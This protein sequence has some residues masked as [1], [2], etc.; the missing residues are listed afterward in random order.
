MKVTFMRTILIL[1]F[2]I[3]AA[4]FAQ[5]FPEA[6]VMIRGGQSNV[7]GLVL[8]SSNGTIYLSGSISYN[9][10]ANRPVLTGTGSA[11]GLVLSA[12]TDGG[13]GLILSGN[14][15]YNLLSNLPQLLVGGT[16]TASKLTLSRNGQV[17][18]LGGSIDYNDLI[19]KPA[20][21]SG[22]S[23]VTGLTLSASNG[24]ITL[25][26]SAGG[27]LTSGSSQVTGLTLSASN[28]V[29]VLSGSAGGGGLTSGSS[30]VEGLTLSASNGVLV[31]GGT[32][33][34]SS[35]TPVITTSEQGAA[36][37]Q[38]GGVTLGR[39][40]L[41]VKATTAAKFID[42]ND[43]GE[44]I[45]AEQAAD[46]N[47]YG[48]YQYGPTAD[49]WGGAVFKI[50]QDGTVT[51]LHHTPTSGEVTTWGKMPNGM[52][53]DEAGQ[54][55]IVSN[56]YGG[57]DN[58][59]T[60]I[61]VS[62]SSGSTTVLKA[63]TSADGSNP[64]QLLESGS[65]YYGTCQW[66]GNDGRGTA[67]KIEKATGT[68]TKLADFDSTDLASM[69]PDGIGPQL[70]EYNGDFYGVA[71]PRATVNNGLIFKLTTSGSLSA[72]KT[73]A[74]TAET[75]KRAY[76]FNGSKLIGFRRGASPANLAAVD[77]ADGNISTIYNFPTSGYHDAADD[78]HVL[79]TDNG[80]F[81]ASRNF[82]SY[83]GADA[84]S[85]GQ[86]FYIPPEGG[87]YTSL[88]VFNTSVAGGD[89]APTGISFKHGVMLVG[90][91]AG[92]AD[93]INYGRFWKFS[94]AIVRLAPEFRVISGTSTV[95][96]LTI[97]TGTDGVLV[98]SGSMP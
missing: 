69:A 57:P 88:K 90:T 6:D 33:A 96:G 22:T 27:G 1:F 66:G 50:A 79:V 35:S 62:M 3:A 26:G 95:P 56:G 51:I 58:I 64:S 75:F 55:L 36:L 76:G 29:L 65:F 14:V 9:D 38:E 10:L 73:F 83:E 45:Y 13:F 24:V 49:N 41:V 4:G 85:D 60:I 12:R 18:V 84:G 46:G 80:Y 48:V 47:L 63:F 74:S 82:N 71:P 61:A 2:A 67:F 86:V 11:S 77:L 89:G 37:N 92:W 23:Q 53:M 59:G 8:S 40:S 25:S 93:T 28:G 54:R 91:T 44:Y 98:L 94:Q 5:T 19:N 43:S 32:V 87:S 16:S 39:A 7:P 30:Q 70:F 52:V 81:L 78:L 15:D 97:T 31:L 42:A 21:V 68:F 34:G 17:L 72:V 20:A